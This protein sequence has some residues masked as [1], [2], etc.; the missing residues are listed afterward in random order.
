M[1]ERYAVAIVLVAVLW[2]VIKIWVQPSEKVQQT[3][4]YLAGGALAIVA[5]RLFLWFIGWM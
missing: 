4:N 5:I 3:V 2:G 1:I